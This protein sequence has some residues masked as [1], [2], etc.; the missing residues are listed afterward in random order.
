MQ[1]NGRLT[2]KM[3]ELWLFQIFDLGG[4]V[5]RKSEVKIEEF[6]RPGPKSVVKN[7]QPEISSKTSSFL[8]QILVLL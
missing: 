4:R 7:V 6:R 8:K 5:H 2:F 1:N 3:T